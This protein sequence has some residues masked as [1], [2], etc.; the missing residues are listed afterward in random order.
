MELHL[1]END[2]AV[3]AT[4]GDAVILALPENGTTGYQWSVQP[5]GNEVVVESSEFAPPESAAPGASGRRV[6]RLRAVR[7][8][9]AKVDVRLQR[10]WETTAT[11]RRDLAITVRA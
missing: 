11:D 6:I 2:Q 9:T 4:V 3:E 8:G 1:G 5:K 10:P 7:A